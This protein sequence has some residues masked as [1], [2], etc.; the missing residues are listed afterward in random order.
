MNYVEFKDKF[1]DHLIISKNEI[2][3][4]FKWFDN[5]NLTYW[6]KKWYISKIINNYYYFNELKLN[7]EKLFYISNS[8]YNPSYISSYSALSYY[9][10]IPEQVTYIIW[11]STNPT[12]IYKTD[13]WIFKYHSIK[14][15]L[16]W[17]YN[18]KSIWK[19]SFY[20]ED[21]EKTILDFFL[22]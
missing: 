1:K 21:I 3:M 4:N 15:E 22:L 19:Y 8:I 20:I 6:Q 18:I 11:I 17:W 9:N 2:L 5:K 10:L 13:I 14:K 16:F 7:L 12:K